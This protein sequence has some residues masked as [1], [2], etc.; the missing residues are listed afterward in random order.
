MEKVVATERAE[1]N[2]A[3]KKAFVQQVDEVLPNECGFCVVNAAR[4]ILK[5]RFTV[6]PQ[7][8]EFRKT[9]APHVSRPPPRTTPH[10]VDKTATRPKVSI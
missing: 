8:N 7:S 4:E 9:Y 3:S 2:V 1:L 5:L 10:V 6:R